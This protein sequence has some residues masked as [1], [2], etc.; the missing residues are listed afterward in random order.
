MSASIADGTRQ[1]FDPMF[2]ISFE[3][4]FTGPP[5]PARFRWSLLSRSTYDQTTIQKAY[6][7]AQKHMAYY[8]LLLS[9]GTAFLLSFPNLDTY[10]YVGLTRLEI[11]KKEGERKKMT[12]E[13]I[14]EQIKFETAWSH[15]C[16]RDPK[17]LEGR[18]L[19]P[20]LRFLH[21]FIPKEA[22]VIRE[23][24][25]FGGSVPSVSTTENHTHLVFRVYL[26]GSDFNLCELADIEKKQLL[27]KDLLKE[28]QER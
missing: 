28:E 9:R 13:E 20:P 8:Q 16:R 1:L 4:P 19:L 7:I 3:L 26:G 22:T 10:E 24:T 17:Y 2:G 23:Q 15:C 14:E 5:P 11:L 12:P 27:P 6:D 18:E 25:L 21:L